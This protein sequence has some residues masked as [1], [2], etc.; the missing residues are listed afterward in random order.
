MDTYTQT[1]PHKLEP[2]EPRDEEYHKMVKELD[3]AV[4]DQMMTED[5]AL[6]VFKK[7]VERTA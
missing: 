5:E 3:K 7:K 4:K 1:Y 6:A 2:R